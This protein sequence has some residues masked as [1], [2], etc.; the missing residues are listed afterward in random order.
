MGRLLS[1]FTEISNETTRSV[2]QLI[3]MEIARPRTLPLE[4]W[5]MIVEYALHS[6]PLHWDRWLQTR[7]VSRTFKHIV[8]KRFI[9]HYLSRRQI[10]CHID[11]A[12]G[13][14]CRLLDFRKLDEDC[15]GKAIFSDDISDV[16][17][18]FQ[19]DISDNSDA[20][21]TLT[22]ADWARPLPRIVSIPPATKLPNLV[23]TDHRKIS[24]CHCKNAA[25]T[26]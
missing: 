8:E 9:E 22:D 19:D 24:R 15:S 2:G 16:L 6:C 18:V 13:M 21:D 17:A 26:T 23:L 10:V 12:Y 5:I 3:V 11:I 1:M 20:S 4:L 14:N 25:Y 7:L